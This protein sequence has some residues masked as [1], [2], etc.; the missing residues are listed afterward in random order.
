MGEGVAE[1]DG[2]GSG[3]GVGLD[4][5]VGVGVGVG[6]GVVDEPAMA[7][8]SASKST[9]GSVPFVPLPLNGELTERR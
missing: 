1:G 4:V 8:L 9:P 7:A 6:G 3:V 2:D 5:G